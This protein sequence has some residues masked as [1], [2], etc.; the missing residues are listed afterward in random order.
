[1][2]LREHRGFAHGLKPGMAGALDC[3]SCARETGIAIGHVL[4]FELWPP[5][6][7]DKPGAQ[8]PIQLPGRTRRITGRTVELARATAER[9][10]AAGWTIG[11][12]SHI[13]SACTPP[14]PG[15]G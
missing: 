11:A 10:L 4:V 9:E 12:A 3:R 7:F 1:M 14:H 15:T 5:G 6:A 13:R 8:Y 2:K